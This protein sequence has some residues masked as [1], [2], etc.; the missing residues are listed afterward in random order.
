MGNWKIENWKKTENYTALIIGRCSKN[1][2]L[3]DTHKTKDT[4]FS[5]A[6]GDGRLNVDGSFLLAFT[7][8]CLIIFRL[9]LIPILLPQNTVRDLC[10]LLHKR[11]DKTSQNDSQHKAIHIPVILA[12]IGNTDESNPPRQNLRI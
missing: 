1:F 10:V 7:P 2:F 11:F 5:S 4:S 3:C 12:R 8:S 6:L 9:I